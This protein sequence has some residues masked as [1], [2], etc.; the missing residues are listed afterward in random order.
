[1]L[2]L[3]NSRQGCSGPVLFNCID[4]SES[5][6]DT[7]K[8]ESQTEYPKYNKKQHKFKRGSLLDMKK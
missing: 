8:I 6:T 4:Y 5:N 2:D 3:K 1:M 7:D